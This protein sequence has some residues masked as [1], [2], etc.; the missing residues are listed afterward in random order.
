MA[1]VINDF[2]VVLEPPAKGDDQGASAG[3]GD[4]KPQGSSPRDIE[5]VVRRLSERLDRVRAH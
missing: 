2:E 4:S 5:R 3:G 1:V